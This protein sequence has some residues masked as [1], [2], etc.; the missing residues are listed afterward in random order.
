MPRILQNPGKRRLIA[1]AISAALLSTFPQPTFADDGQAGNP[2]TVSD[3]AQGGGGGTMDTTT[4][5]GG[6]GGDGGSGGRGQGSSRGENGGAGSMDGVDNSL[7][8]GTPTGGTGQ[9]PDGTATNGSGSGGGG[10]GGGSAGKVLNS[11]SGD[12]SGDIKGGN[13]GRGGNGGSNTTDVAD[14]GNGGNGGDGGDGGAGALITGSGSYTNSGSITGGDGGTGGNTGSATA[15]DQTTAGETLHGGSGGAGGAGGDGVMLTQD[16]NVSNTG[17]ITGGHGA[18]GGLAA[19]ADT[20][21]NA[22]VTGVGGSGGEAAEGGRG[23]WLSGTSTITNSGRILGGDGGD[24]GNGGAVESGQ[25]TGVVGYGSAGGNGG[26]G[27]TVE[28]S[29]KVINTQGGHI[30]GGNAGTGGGGNSN[31][32]GDNLSGGDGGDGGKGGIGIELEGGGSVSNFGE[33]TGGLGNRGGGSGN[34]STSQGGDSGAGGIG[35]EIDGGDVTNES[36]GVVT[37]GKGGDDSAGGGGVGGAGGDAVSIVGAGNV[38]NH[39]AFVGGNG[40]A[41]ANGNSPTSD[42]GS[43][44]KGGNGLSIEGNGTLT[45]DAGASITGGLGGTGGGSGGDT[46]RGGNGG[47]GGSGVLIGAGGQVVN[48][49]DILGGTGNRG[50]GGGGNAGG[51]GG[52]GI[53]IVSGGGSVVNTGRISGGNGGEPGT[54]GG[55]N[56]VGDIGVGGVGISGSDMTIVNSGTISGGLDV[57]RQNRSQ[58]V[59]FTG[60]INSL[61]LRNGYNMQGNVRATGGDDTLILGGDV[62]SQFDAASIGDSAQYAGFGHFHKK[63]ASTWALNNPTSATTPWTLYDGILQVAENGALGSDA[64][65][66][67]FD[68][69]TLQLSNSFDLDRPI[70]L[71]SAGGTLDTQAFNT[72]ISQG[73]TGSGSLIKLGSGALTMIGDSTYTGTTTLAEGSLDVTGSLVSDVTAKRA[74]LLSGTGSIGAA[75][76]ETGSTLTVGSPLQGNDDAASFSVNGDLDNRG[77]V[78]LSRRATISGN[79]LNVSGDYT[80][81]TDS[82]LNVNTVLGDDVSVTDKLVIQGATSGSTMLAVVNVGGQGAETQQG[83]EV[84][85]VGGNSAAG[86]FTQSGRI[87]AGAWDY[88]LVQKGQNWYLTSMSNLPPEPP[89]DPVT[90]PVDP[91]TPPVDPVDPVGPTTPPPQPDPVPV[92]RPEAGSYLVN[93]TAANTLFNLTLDDREGATEY[94][95]PLDERGMA[96]STFWLRQ[97]GGQNRFHTGG[98]QI[99][100][101][102]NRYV[103]QMGNE[104]LHGSSHQ[105]D[106]WGAGL[107]AGYGNVQ[108][109]AR[110][111]LTG[112]RSESEL[113][114]YSVGAYGTWYQNAV[115]RKGV[116]VD[117]WVMYNWFNNSVSGDDLPNE[118]YKSR[119]FTA[120]LE[121][122]YNMLLSESERQ[123]V[124]LEPQAQLTWMGVHSAEHTE[125][126]GTRVQDNGQGN[127]QSRL[128]VRLYLRG[129]RTEDDGKGREFKPYVETDWLHNT[130]NF[131]VRMGDKLLNEE[132]AR[133]I[134]QLR[135]G[136][137]GQ[138]AHDLNMWGG[139]AQQIG[140][141]GYHDTSAMAGMKYGF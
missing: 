126:N 67:T 23:V 117:G 12:N 20:K 127:L 92:Y 104:F 51:A 124:Y 114:G 4:G 13:G 94:R 99:S 130:K 61:E 93:L 107:M 38:T 6:N 98:G 14:A 58:A 16:G 106:R 120:S 54:A 136:V 119:G 19:N 65:L 100:S 34:L 110:S 28:G 32:T 109:N 3:S 91:V 140:D 60:G 129:H 22:N 81:G 83:I 10:G 45:N 7:P 118:D 87:V 62:N 84:V 1:T 56:G 75:A 53:S 15:N 2:A 55:I 36:S 137:Q 121:S 18:T 90:P 138:I 113:D 57:E 40:G 79:R 105:T 71:E 27:I 63:G 74:T 108:G 88:R 30:I 41:G 133:N 102:A 42:G 21:N 50:G 134:G 25:G 24:G 82:Q 47:E 103:A 49:G 80:G 72:A 85:T 69:G 48:N 68:G 86:A 73:V 52:A 89:V 128:G 135:L 131:G 115:S 112:Y 125:A 46:S 44:A 59:L 31:S 95:T 11:S 8:P 132:G 70:T 17:T 5:I 29:G 9:E 33:V 76:L 139:V 97:E 35:I 116:Y 77:I 111:N 26:S 123:A 64:S 43:G 141:K 78:N 66:L 39:G 101:S 37:G 96:R 122:G